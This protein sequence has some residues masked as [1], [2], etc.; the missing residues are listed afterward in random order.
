MS[1]ILRKPLYWKPTDLVHQKAKKSMDF[2]AHSEK[3]EI[4]KGERIEIVHEQAVRDYSYIKELINFGI[5][6]LKR[7]GVDVGGVVLDLGSGTGVGASILSEHAEFS[8]ILAVEISESFV[9]QIMPLVFENFNAN[10]ELIQRVVGDFNHIEMKDN[11]VDAIIELD[12]FH[13]SEDL[14]RTLE[15]C[16]RV[17]RNGGVMIC[18]DRG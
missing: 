8:N 12:S 18:I 16:Y 4:K 11:S 17:L 5:K 3:E 9:N 1:T 2:R 14:P 15:E 7:K 10:T 6:F 13:H